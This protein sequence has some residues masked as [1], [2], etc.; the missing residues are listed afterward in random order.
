MNRPVPHMGALRSYVEKEAH[1]RAYYEYRRILSDAREL[2]GLLDKI[3]PNWTAT[4][5]AILEHLEAQARE[6]VTF[7]IEQQYGSVVL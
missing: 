6:Q 5:G 1:R 3:D 4:D 2:V 7:E